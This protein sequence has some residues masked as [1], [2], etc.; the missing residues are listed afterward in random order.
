MSDFLFTTAIHAPPRLCDELL[1]LMT[2]SI[3]K[4]QAIQHSLE[5][6]TPVGILIVGMFLL[7]WVAIAV[8]ARRHKQSKLIGIGGGFVASLFLVSV[9][10]AAITSSRQ[11]EQTPTAKSSPAVAQPAVESRQVVEQKTG[12]YFV[13]EQFTPVCRDFK[14]VIRVEA[15][16]RTQNEQAMRMILANTGCQILSK[17]VIMS[18][19]TTIRS[20]PAGVLVADV[21]A[22]MFFF[23]NH[24]LSE[25]YLTEADAKRR[26]LTAMSH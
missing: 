25:E 12:K 20:M 23:A 10:T 13:I 14:D 17:E 9:V 18:G 15:V 22:G 16:V 3:G 21:P 19:K 6:E 24:H 26:V 7:V 4:L 5:K 1:E 11:E 8:F 2:I